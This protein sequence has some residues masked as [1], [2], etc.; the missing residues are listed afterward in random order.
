MATYNLS[1]H[2]VL[3]LGYLL[4]FDF[5]N[6]ESSLEKEYNCT[7]FGGNEADRGTRGFSSEGGIFKLLAVITMG[8]LIVS[9]IIAEWLRRK[10][11]S[12]E[13]LRPRDIPTR[14]CCCTI[15]IAWYIFI[16]YY[17]LI[18]VNAIGLNIWAIFG[19]RKDFSSTLGS[20]ENEW[21]IGQVLALVLF[22]VPVVEF[23]FSI[24][25]LGELIQRALEF[26][27]S[28]Y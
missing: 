8:V 23:L 20:A 19:L 25:P 16:G 18:A 22:L 9:T 28:L 17:F 10:V 11:R 21:G 3:V 5:G 24:W 15:K 26:A 12:T 27:N 4:S 2:S 7:P 6:N 13:R 14:L 1:C